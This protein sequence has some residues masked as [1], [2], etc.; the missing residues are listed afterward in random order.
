[1]GVYSDCPSIGADGSRPPSSRSEYLLIKYNTNGVL[2]TTLGYGLYATGRGPFLDMD[3]TS[4]LAMGNAAANMAHEIG[5]V[6]PRFS[7]DDFLT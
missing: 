5:Y 3:P 4:T 7:V 6:R 2:R 1:M